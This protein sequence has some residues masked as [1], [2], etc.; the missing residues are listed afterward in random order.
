MTFLRVSE[1]HRC[2]ITTADD[3]LLYDGMFSALCLQKVKH[4]VAVTKNTFE[5]VGFK[6]FKEQS[7]VFL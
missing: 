7:Q 6:L 3:L 2:S 4:E 1:Y 5:E